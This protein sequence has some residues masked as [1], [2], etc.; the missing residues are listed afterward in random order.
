M[1]EIHGL[2][3]AIITP[4]NADETIHVEML[5]E[6][7]RRQLAA[8]VHG[9]FC[10]GT[11]GEF[12]S[13]TLEEKQTIMET[14]F[15]EVKGQCPVIAGVGC[16]TTQETVALARDAERIGVDA[17]SVIV[18]YFVGV[19]QDQLYRHYRRVAEAVSVPVLIYNIPMRTGNTIEPATV[20][21]LAEV[22]NIIGIKDSSGNMDS[23]RSLIRE[24]GDDFS[25]F[26][27][28]DSLILDT[29]LAGGAGAVSGCANVFPEI[30]VRIYESWRAG[31]IADA[32]RVQAMVNPIRSTFKL[33][34]PNSIV[35][36]AVNLL[37]YPVG[38][39]REPVNIDSPEIDAAI[40]KAIE[41]TNAM[42]DR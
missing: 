30:M 10:L 2:M 5:R 14:V 39:A 22:E 34:N 18:P 15:D 36:R 16:I 32:Q 29:L 40:R 9:I 38:P 26:V 25:V 41:D 35:K 3:P 4:M 21:S 17:I 6:Q 13:L 33:G 23:V 1:S 8:G 24:T 31:D 20:V 12:Y 28:T 11:N 42:W 19:A 7:V 27:G 37:G